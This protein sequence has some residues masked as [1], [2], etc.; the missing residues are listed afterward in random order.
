MSKGKTRQSNVGFKTVVVLAALQCSRK[1]E[2]EVKILDLL[3]KHTTLYFLSRSLVLS[4]FKIGEN[5]V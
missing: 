5:V 4:Y 3:M 1:P 2:F